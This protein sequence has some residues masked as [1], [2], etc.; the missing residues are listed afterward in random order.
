[1][2]WA[3]L[4]KVHTGLQ[5]EHVWAVSVKA[6]EACTVLKEPLMYSKVWWATLELGLSKLNSSVAHPRLELTGQ[7]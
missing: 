5:L 2:I 3:K 1:M 7:H 6:T 4:F